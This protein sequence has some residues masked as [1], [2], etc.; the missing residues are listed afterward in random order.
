M[1]W[2]AKIYDMFNGWNDNEHELPSTPA[3]KSING[4]PESSLRPK[5][6]RH[7]STNDSPYLGRSHSISSVNNPTNYNKQKYIS[8]LRK[9]NNITFVVSLVAIDIFHHMVIVFIKTNKDL[10]ELLLCML[11]EFF[12]F[13]F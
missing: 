6:T 4:L 3:V 10:T 12:F 7:T 5:V 8:F 13:M 2:C 9:N 1:S 11:I